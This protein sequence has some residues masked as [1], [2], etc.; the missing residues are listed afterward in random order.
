MTPLKPEA[1]RKVETRDEAV[2]R[3]VASRV[4]QGFP[5]TVEDPVVLRKVATLLDA[6]RRRAAS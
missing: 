5:A 2:D 4:E 1:K 3:L 6:A